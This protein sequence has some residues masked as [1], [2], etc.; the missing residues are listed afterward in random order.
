MKQH[1]TKSNFCVQFCLYFSIQ[2]SRK[3]PPNHM[4][5]SLN[6]VGKM[7]PGNAPDC[8]DFNL[9]FKIFRGSMP[10]DPPR[11]AR[12]FA[13]RDRRFAPIVGPPLAQHLPT[14]LVKNRGNERL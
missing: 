7:C 2:F 1:Q 9:D 6:K 5:F 12:R 10:P 14:P 11:E 3:K 13:P 8:T 4:K